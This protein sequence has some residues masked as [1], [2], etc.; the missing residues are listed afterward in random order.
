MKLLL[1]I[2]PIFFLSLPAISA[3]VSEAY[4]N[5][6]VWEGSDITG[7]A[8]DAYP[9]TAQAEWT[10][11]Q[12]LD[13]KTIVIENTDGSNSLDYKILY[14]VNSSGTMLDYPNETDITIAA[15]QAALVSIPEQANLIDVYIKNTTPGQNATFKISV[16]GRQ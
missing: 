13:L 10:F 14:R 12:Y 15:G 6:G 16:G 8:A 9:G 4:W 1:I 11:A 7:T 5:A 3:E 2:I